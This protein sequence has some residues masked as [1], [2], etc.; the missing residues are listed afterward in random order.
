MFQNNDG[1]QD[2]AKLATKLLLRLCVSGYVIFLGYKLVKNIGAEGNPIPP[3]ASVAIAAVFA[4]AGVA[5]IVYSIF[6]HRKNTAALT[7]ELRENAGGISCE[8]VLERAEQRPALAEL[9]ALYRTYLQKTVELE[10]TRKPFDGLFGLGN[11]PQKDA[12]HDVFYDGVG[13]AVKKLLDDESADGE[14][15]REAMRLILEAPDRS[16]V[17][18]LAF[19]MLLAAHGHCTE[20]AEKLTPEEDLEFAEYYDDTYD[21]TERMPVQSRLLSTLRELGGWCS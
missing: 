10:A 4:L 15:R 2:H 3:W 9:A 12:C 18:R 17:N 8:D 14:D 1:T 21:R 6:D 20:L 13:E 11:S 19:P 16:R 7:E 5:F